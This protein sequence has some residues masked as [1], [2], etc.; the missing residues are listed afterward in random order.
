ME[1]L[2]W[3]KCDLWCA[4]PVSPLKFAE[5]VLSWL[6]IVAHCR[7]QGWPILSRAGKIS[8][9]SDSAMAAWQMPSIFLP[10]RFSRPAALKQALVGSPLGFHRFPL[11]TGT[12]YLDSSWFRLVPVPW[13][14]AGPFWLE[15]LDVG[16]RQAW[17]SLGPCPAGCWS[18]SQHQDSKQSLQS[19]QRVVA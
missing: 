13:G 14:V 1:V 11:A 4:S 15:C 6:L 12:G 9:V 7:R 2:V 16:L 19:L 18:W 10:W 8:Q 3:S 5:E 17:P